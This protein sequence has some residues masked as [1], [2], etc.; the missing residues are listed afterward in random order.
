MN[1][2]TLLWMILIKE[3]HS[4]IVFSL[5]FN[6]LNKLPDA[7]FKIKEIIIK[8]DSNFLISFVLTFKWH[9]LPKGNSIDSKIISGGK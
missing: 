9:D 1:D 7:L 4:A 6:K 3:F 8:G 2:Q 5:S